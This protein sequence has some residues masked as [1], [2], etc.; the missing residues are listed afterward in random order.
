MSRDETPPAP[1]RALRYAPASSRN[2]EPI[3]EVL[4]PLLAGARVVLEV[5]SGSGEHAV[6]LASQMPHLTWQPTDPDPFARA[7]I[8]GWRAHSGAV[9]VRPALTLDATSS[10]WPVSTADAV[11]CIN[12]IH[13]APWAAC[14]GLLRGASAVLSP[15]DVLFLYGPFKERGQHTAPS[16]EAFDADLRAR[17]DTW[18]VRDLDEVIALAGTLGFDHRTTARMPANNLSVVLQRR[19]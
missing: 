10:P 6:W 5:A 1:A 18:G 12:M 2:R 17:N 13:I 3:L 4:A 16:N 7:S 11:V 9:N 19:V 8:D 15:G 14:V